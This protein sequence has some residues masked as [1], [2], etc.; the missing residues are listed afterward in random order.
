[1]ENCVQFMGKA[2]IETAACIGDTKNQVRGQCL[3][4]VLCTNLVKYGEHGSRGA[5]APAFRR[6]PFHLALPRPN[7]TSTNRNRSFHALLLWPPF[8]TTS[9][10]ETAKNQISRQTFDRPASK[11]PSARLMVFGL[12]FSRETFRNCGIGK[13]DQIARC[14]KRPR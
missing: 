14:S 1:M 12:W 2:T 7:R 5:I 6:K 11:L 4:S 13:T 8:R 3:F 10:C 9:R